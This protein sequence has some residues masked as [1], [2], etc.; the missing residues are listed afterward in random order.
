MLRLSDEEWIRVVTLREETIRR[1]RA[2]PLRC[3]YEPPI[4]LVCDALL[5]VPWVDGA[6][7]EAIRKNLGYDSPVNV[8]YLLGAQRSSKTEY[9][10]NRLMRLALGAEDGLTWMFHNTMPASIDAHQPRVW[11]YLPPG[12]RGKA[13]MSQTTYV[14][15]KAKTGFTDGALVLPNRHRIRFM[16]YEIDLEALQ[17]FNVSAVAADEFVSPE[18]VE[19][20]KARV[21][22]R[23]GFVIVMLAPINGYTPLVQSACD[24]AKVVRES[25]AYLNPDDGGPR[26]VPRYLG[27]SEEEAEKMGDF[28]TRRMKRPYPNVPYARPEDCSAWL[29]GESGQPLPPPGRKFKRVPRIQRPVDVEGR[30]AIVH[31]HGND[32]PFGNP[33]SLV[34]LNAGVSEEIGNR[35]FYGLAKEGMVK[36]FRLYDTGVQCVPDEAIPAGG[37]NY[38]FIDPAGRNFFITWVRVFGR[39]SYVYRE[40]P[41][42]YEVPG[43]GIPGPWAVPDGKLGDGRRGPAQE[44]FGYGL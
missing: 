43:Q 13:I 18:H 15:Y 1:E 25:I 36:M 29:R 21:A 9:A 37:T 32:N 23:N 44:S 12:L 19:T 16:S 41:G 2:E 33:L 6:E 8:L 30:S 38:M 5:G 10:I 31:F 11:H 42:N 40:W 20:F 35:I 3:L 28:L 7:A 17:G 26:D 27:L 39:N 34:R 24:G 4:W 22:V 14:S